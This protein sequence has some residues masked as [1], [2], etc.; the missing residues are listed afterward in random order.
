MKNFIFGLLIVILSL[1][2]IILSNKAS[3]YEAKLTE[4]NL[5]IQFGMLT[6]FGNDDE[7]LK[8]WDKMAKDGSLRKLASWEPS[9]NAK[10]R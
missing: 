9:G 8:M 2:V 6:N 1:Q 7:G 5:T 4:L 10:Y 3:K